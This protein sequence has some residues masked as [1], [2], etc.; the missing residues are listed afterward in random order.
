[1][2]WTGTHIIGIADVSNSTV[3]RSTNG[4]TWASETVST[5]QRVKVVSNG[6]GTVLAFTSTGA[7]DISTDHGDTWTTGSI[8]GFSGALFDAVWFNGQFIVWTATGNMYS[9]ANGVTWSATAPIVVKHP[10]KSGFL[11]YGYTYRS[12]VECGGVLYGLFRGTYDS[13]T[14]ANVFYSMD[15]A[16][17]MD[18]GTIW[19]WSVNAIDA[20]STRFSVH[21]SSTSTNVAASLQSE[22]HQMAGRIVDMQHADFDLARD[23]FISPAVVAG[24]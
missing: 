9:S 2:A 14:I 22:V 7:I 3:G 6:S 10:G 13:F 18:S 17:W 15:G 21:L 8:A 4:T 1:M 11:P 5:A 23:W 12:I 24:I 16:T 20:L 19:G